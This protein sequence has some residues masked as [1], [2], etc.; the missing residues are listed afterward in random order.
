M[1]GRPRYAHWVRDLFAIVRAAFAWGDP[2]KLRRE[3]GGWPCHLCG[4]RM[5]VYE[6]DPRARGWF[7]GECACGAWCDIEPERRTKVTDGL[8]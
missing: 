1:A 3:I 8:R 7:R 5:R 4:A 6:G 2:E